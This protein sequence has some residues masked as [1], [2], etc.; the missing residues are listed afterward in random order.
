MLVP[1]TLILSQTPSLI[2]SATD[3]LMKSRRWSADIAT[4]KDLGELRDRCAE[5]ARDQQA[6]AELVKELTEQLKALTE[7]VRATTTRARWGIIVGTLGTTLGAVA[8]VAAF[9]R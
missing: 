5:L 9:L 7:A 8:C 3:L 1:W 4:T 2:S 6:Y